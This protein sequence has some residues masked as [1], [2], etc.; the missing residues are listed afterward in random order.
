MVKPTEQ[1]VGLNPSA[2]LV[3][4]GKGQMGAGRR[5][6]ADSDFLPV[7]STQPVALLVTEDVSCVTTDTCP[8]YVVQTLLPLD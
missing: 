4:S 1:L 2:K 8:A 6:P 3:Y 5:F 7:F